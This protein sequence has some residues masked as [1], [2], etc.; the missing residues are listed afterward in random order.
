MIP[1]H[2]GE[3]LGADKGVGSPFPSFFFFLTITIFLINYK[4]FKKLK[5][6]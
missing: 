4:T 1:I 3:A 5:T 6:L 2:I